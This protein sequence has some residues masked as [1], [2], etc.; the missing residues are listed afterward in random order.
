MNTFFRIFLKTQIFLGVWVWVWN[1]V[2]LGLGFGLGF[3][4]IPIIQKQR[5]QKTSIKSKPKRNPNEIVCLA[6]TF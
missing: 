1:L 4:F 5:P 6:V 3:G 2:Y